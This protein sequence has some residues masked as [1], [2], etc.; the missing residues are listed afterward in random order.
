[1]VNERLKKTI[2]TALY[3]FGMLLGYIIS[4]GAI[5]MG[6]SIGTRVIRYIV[7]LAQFKGL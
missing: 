6:F 3:I 2:E 1:M 5:F 4:L 7:F